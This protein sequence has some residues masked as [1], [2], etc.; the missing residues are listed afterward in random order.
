MAIKVILVDDHRILREGIKTILQETSDIEVLSEADNGR[1]AVKLAEEL[2]PDIMVMDLAMPELNGMEATEMITRA[3]PGIKVIALSMHSDQ[4]YIRGIFQAGASGFVLKH[5]AA[6]ELLDAIRLVHANHTYLSKEIS[7]VV[8]KEFSRKVE[9]NA[10]KVKALSS[11]EKEVLQLVAE[12]KTTK[13]IAETL[14]VS[15]KTVEAH[16]QNI[17]NK[18]NLF[19]IPELTKYAIKTGLTSLEG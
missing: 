13:V 5:S 7:D 14:F 18:L 9:D 16:R 8:V 1:D 19:T 15:I 4:H 11:R 3:N 2:K 12:G 17:M 6:K 10:S